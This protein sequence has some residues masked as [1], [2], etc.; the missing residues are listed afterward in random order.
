MRRILLI[1]CL[2]CLCVISHK[3]YAY[4]H[5][6]NWQLIYTHRDLQIYYDLNY[7]S[8]DK[9]FYII[10]HGTEQSMICTYIMRDQRY[11]TRYLISYHYTEKAGN[12]IKISWNKV[13]EYDGD[14][15]NWHLFRT[16]QPPENYEATGAMYI[17]G[18]K[19]FDMYIREEK[20]ET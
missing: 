14:I 8:C 10:E 20:E 16:F 6:D 18:K 7:I 5:V 11:K 12:L 2:C 1:M 17:I 19:L 4:T 15:N 13:R 3:V 9:R